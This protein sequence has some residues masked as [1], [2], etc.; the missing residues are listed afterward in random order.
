MDA[1]TSAEKPAVKISIVVPVYNDAEYLPTCLD[2]LINQTLKEIEILLVNDGST[3]ASLAIMNEY[4]ARDSR[5][6]VFSFPEN[7]SAFTARNE[8]IRNASGEYIMFADGDDYYE[9]DAC[10]RVWE[11]EQEN[12]VDILNYNA[13]VISVGE[14]KATQVDY[15]QKVPNGYLQGPEVFRALINVKITVLLWNKCFRRELCLR[16]VRE[17]G[18]LFIPKSN[19]DLFMWVAAFLASSLRGYPSEILYNHCFGFGTEGSKE[20]PDIQLFE[21]FLQS[22]WTVNEIEK[23][24]QKNTDGE[25]E[26]SLKR[27]RWGFIFRCTAFWSDMSPHD[28][29]EAL[30][31]LLRYWSKPGDLGRIAGAF[32]SVFG[33]RQGELADLLAPIFRERETPTPKKTIRTIGIY[34]RRYFNDGV[35]RILSL[36]FPIWVRMGY[37]VVFLTGVENKNDY[38]LP[39]GVI[40]VNCAVPEGDS[41]NGYTK[42]GEDWEN[43][44]RKYDIDVM[45][46]HNCFGNSQLWDTLLCRL[47][48]VPVLTYIHGSV[49]TLLRF[50]PATALIPGAARVGNGVITLNEMDRTF[51]SCVAPDT[52]VFLVKN[53]LTFDPATVE[54]SDPDGPPVI[55]WVA[56]LALRQKRYLDPVEIMAE[57]VKCVPDAK[58]YMVGSGEGNRDLNALNSKITELGLEESVI[59]CGFQMD[60]ASWYRKA[61]VF[62]LTSADESFCSSLAEAL[63]FS[64]PVV[65]YDLPYL[66]LVQGNAGIVSV[67]QLDTA[68]A[69]NAICELLEN[70][71]HRREVGRRGREFIE[72]LYTEDEIAE[73]WRRIF[74][75]V[76]EPDTTPQEPE[77][78]R[79]LLQRVLKE[80]KLRLPVPSGKRKSD[81]ASSSLLRFLYGD[82][83]K[84]QYAELRSNGPPNDLAVSLV[85]QQDGQKRF[86]ILLK[87]DGNRNW[88]TP[89]DLKRFTERSAPSKTALEAQLAQ[90]T[91]QFKELQAKELQVRRDTLAEVRKALSGQETGGEWPCIRFTYGDV[92][93]HQYTELRSSGP[94]DNRE[95]SLVSIQEDGK[96][97]FNILLNSDGNRNWVTPE[98]LKT[99]SERS[100]ASKTALEAKVVSLTAQLERLQALCI[101]NV[102]I[103]LALAGTAFFIWRG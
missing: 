85:T 5:I 64:L 32:S 49:E 73:Q 7:R 69:A 15:I 59:P 99:L 20:S 67:P 100:S 22:S 38:P 77:V 57:V 93:K 81:P 63:T 43:L 33:K 87:S 94:Q 71:E 68:A 17:C 10:E 3:D 103:F 98:E 56:R 11:L 86:N 8:G 37:R 61:S 16:V 45:V 95:V 58:L 90:L 48:G 1:Q 78:Y 19:D 44:L 66:T 6:R 25:Y 79:E 34:Y 12:P 72:N 39:K 23:F 52:K 2:S 36:I 70:Q 76:G 82:A 92:A 51:W 55:L 89:E 9:L 50:T 40:R 30:R 96:K 88:V 42:R 101:V 80:Y 91:E 14:G 29:P 35:A 84:Q 31:L 60:M 13:N 24:I 75:D 18:D 41:A 21:V 74:D 62:L 26:A 54:P 97:R 28:Q 4:A 46:Y 47:M 83:A 65:M 27:K 102:I 53:P